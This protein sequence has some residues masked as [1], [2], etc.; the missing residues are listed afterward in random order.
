MVNFEKFNRHWEN[1]FFYPYEKKRDYFE[2]LLGYLNKKQIIALTG[3]RRTGKTV[4]FKQVINYLIKEGIGRKNILYF[5]FDEQKPSFDELIKEYGQITSL[6]L[7]KEE[8]FIF[9]DEVQKLANWQDQIKTY[10]DNYEK[11]KFFVSG[12]ATLFIHKKAHESLSGRIFLLDLPILSF[13]EFLDF[14]GKKE[15]ANNP[16]MFPDQ[17]Q[18]EFSAYLK[19]NFIDII[20]EDDESAKEYLQGIINKIA[21]EDIPQLF[22][23]ENPEK[24]KALITAIYS[25]PGMLINYENLGKDLGL[26]S[27]TTEK[28]LF[29]LIQAKIVKKIYN[30]SKNFLTSEKKSKK[31]Y[32][33]APCMCFLNDEAELSKAIENLVCITGNFDFFWRTPQKDEIDFIS[34]KHS[35]LIPVEVKYSN[36]INPQDLNAINKFS[37]KNKTATPIIITKETEQENKTIKMIPVIKW[38]LEK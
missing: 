30:Y 26:S 25:N 14:K 37:R 12:S 36:K 33:T 23:I 31:V 35:L 9:L 2:V 28:Y 34:K 20:N 22:P 17:I 10:Y 7:G 18:K 5:S 24:L 3:L 32:I 11:V 38:L 16:K 6:E 21:F 29:Y 15:L 27:K 4:L 1:G 13:K 19:R 8:V